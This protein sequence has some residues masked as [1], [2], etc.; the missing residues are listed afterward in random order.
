MLH[1]YLNF[2]MNF[3]LKKHAAGGKEEEEEEEEEH[4]EEDEE[5]EDPSD[6]DEDSFEERAPYASGSVGGS[7]LIFTSYLDTSLLR[8]VVSLNPFAVKRGKG[9]IW[10]EVASDFNAENAKEKDISGNT[11]QKH[12]RK[13]IRDFKRMSERSREKVRVC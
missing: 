9:R 12:T 3:Q 10:D 8:Q 13:L 7:R 6:E 11:A 2:T 4:E 5:E 1:R